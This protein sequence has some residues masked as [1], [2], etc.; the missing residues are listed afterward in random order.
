VVL[1]GQC[2]RAT[3]HNDY[4]PDLQKVCHTSVTLHTNP[5]AASGMALPNCGMEFSPHINRRLR[6]LIAEQQAALDR[7][8]AAETRAEASAAIEAIAYSASVARA[9]AAGVAR[10]IICRPTPEP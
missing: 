9:Y 1:A 3:A 2:P 8:S 7:A 6:E 10:A 4:A 5:L